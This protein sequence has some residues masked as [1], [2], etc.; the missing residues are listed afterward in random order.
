MVFKKLL[1]DKRHALINKNYC[2]STLPKIIIWRFVKIKNFFDD[3]KYGSALKLRKCKG[4]SHS[5]NKCTEELFFEP[6]CRKLLVPFFV[7]KF[8]LYYDAYS[9]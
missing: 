4:L 2:F 7:S 3:D 6:H 5:G 8:K 9:M 1:P